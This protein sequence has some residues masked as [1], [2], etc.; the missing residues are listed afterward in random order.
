ML[1]L[2]GNHDLLNFS[3]HRCCGDYP[4]SEHFF[5]TLKATNKKDHEYVKNAFAV[6]N[7]QPPAWRAEYEKV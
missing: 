2:R 1:K 7:G 5:Q 6:E 4:T 3:N